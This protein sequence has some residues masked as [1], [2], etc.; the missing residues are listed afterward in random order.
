LQVALQNETAITQAHNENRDLECQTDR[1]S[2]RKH[3]WGFK[4]LTRWISR[5][6]KGFLSNKDEEKDR[7]PP[8][9]RTRDTSSPSDEALFLPVCIEKP[10]G[11]TILIQINVAGIT[12]DSYLFACLRQHYLSIRGRWVPYLKFHRLECINFVQFELWPSDEVDVQPFYDQRAVP[13]PSM[14]DEYEFAA[15]PVI[16]P[17][18]S[19]RLMH[20]WKSPG[21]PD[22]SGQTCLDRFPKRRRER[23]YVSLGER[24]AI[25]WGIHLVE[26]LDWVLIW[27]LIFI[28][29]LIGSFVFRIMYSVLDHDIQSAFAISSY[30]ISFFTLGIG[31]CSICGR[32]IVDRNYS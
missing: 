17:I 22:G 5:F 8:E 18:S 27:M 26:G 20:L 13:P 16:P 6:S 2:D 10:N 1:D 29:V 24:P 23:L 30:V 25:G 4:F 11:S 3:R 19:S 31:A 7:S 12:S 21:H 32:R 15:A 28:V 9:K 14:A